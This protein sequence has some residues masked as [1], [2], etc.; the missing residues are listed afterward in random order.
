MKLREYAATLDMKVGCQDN[1]CIWGSPGGMAT[2]GGCRCVD[3]EY[4]CQDLRRR[5]REI[6]LVALGLVRALAEVTAERDALRLTDNDRDALR[7]AL[8]CILVHTG[9]VEDSV[10]QAA[11]DVLARLIKDER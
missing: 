2:N 4:K 9:R 10:S 5:A 3:H 7:A 1:S 11:R 8:T 6:R